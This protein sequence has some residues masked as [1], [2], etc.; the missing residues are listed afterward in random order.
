[1]KIFVDGSKRAAIKRMFPFWEKMGHKIVVSPQEANI[2]LSVIRI[3]HKIKGVP[4]VVR[5]DGVYYDRG[6]R[7]KR[8]NSSLKRSHLKA[9]GI[10]YQSDFSRLMCETYLGKRGAKHFTVIHN[11]INPKGWDNPIEH[12]NVNI[13]SCAKW[14][15]PKRLPE[16]IE[17]FDG[18]KKHIPEAKLHV[19]G[20]F[21]KGGRKI[22]HK[23]VIYYGLVDHDKMAEIYRVGDLYI[24]LCKRDSCPSTVVEAMAAGI[25]VITTNA[26]GG[27]TEMCRLSEGCV[28]V[29]GEDND[30]GPVFVYK[31]DFHKI[32]RDFRNRFVKNSVYLIREKRRIVVPESL[33]AVNAAKKYIEFF[34]KVLSEK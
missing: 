21:K 14:R 1:M 18:I 10:I 19:V 22:P 2:Q 11:G 8:N 29:G 31:D 30:I 17:I 15:R 12:K 33:L 13:M 26:C 27:A 23:D 24:H 5:L 3:R 16:L 4:V 34:E 28:I 6:G 25:P 9:N 32:S 7:Y 20:K